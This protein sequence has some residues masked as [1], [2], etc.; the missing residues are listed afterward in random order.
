MDHAATE[1]A[2]VRRLWAGVLLGYLAL[3][4]TLQELPGYV[5]GHFG[6][7]TWTATVV[8]GIA[9]A[10]TAVARPLAGRGG[11][12]GHS[13]AVVLGGG[14][15]VAV[16]AVGHLVAPSIATLIV[17]RLVM[18]AGE[19]ALF[20][21]ALPW[22][23]VSTP[24]ERRGRATGWFGLSMWTGL[25][26]GPLLAV[27]AANLAGTTA[28]W[29]LVIGLPVLS[30][31]AICTTRPPARLKNR[32][33]FR[34][35]SWRDIMPAGVGLPGLYLGLGAYGYG[36]IS[37]LLVLYL[38][39]SKIGGQDYGLAVF[40]AGFLI[41]RFIGSPL[42]DRIGPR[43]VGRLCVAAAAIGLIALVL[44]TTAPIALA[45]TAVVGV[46]LSLVYPSATGM[47]LVRTAPNVVGATAAAATSFWDLGILGAGL[48]SGA[49][50]DQYGYV[51][52]FQVAAAAA[53]VAIVV[54]FAIRSR[55]SRTPGPK[56]PAHA[57]TNNVAPG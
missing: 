22:V 32:P 40:A 35:T 25:A 33:P 45:S 9:F 12:A 23:L 28:V 50:V 34:P 31:L 43:A 5:V 44:A 37:A 51:G 57:R 53:I 30:V 1:S 20:S 13:R 55:H 4:A 38:A 48:I 19:A 6:G 8:V 18:G 36:T 41:A 56:G 24:T 54:T 21:A 52:A 29:G 16:G 46:G 10:A 3:G 2:P 14:L 26:V 39:T 47:A 42:I 11:D 17:A 49:V 7:S 27:A 15:L